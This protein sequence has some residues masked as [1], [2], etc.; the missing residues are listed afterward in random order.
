MDVGETK[1]LMDG[2]ISMDDLGSAPS[3]S[4]EHTSSEMCIGNGFNV[5]ER[6]TNI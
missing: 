1:S 2:V 5:R 6:R 3:E 4:S